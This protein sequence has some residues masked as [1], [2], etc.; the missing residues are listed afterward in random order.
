MPPAFIARTACREQLYTP[1]TFTLYTRSKSASVHYACPKTEATARSSVQAIPIQSVRDTATTRRHLFQCSN[2]NNARIVDEDVHAAV[3]RNDSVKR[4]FHGDG[5]CDVHSVGETRQSSKFLIDL[6]IEKTNVTS[7]I[8]VRSDLS[9]KTLTDAATEAVSAALMSKMWTKPPWRANSLEMDRPI[10]EAPPVTTAMV[11]GMTSETVETMTI[12]LGVSCTKSCTHRT[13]FLRQQNTAII[14]KLA[15]GIETE[16]AHRPIQTLLHGG[17]RK[18][19]LAWK[20]PIESREQCRTT[21][22]NLFTPTP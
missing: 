14:T 18:A 5:V 15:I 19:S 2:S 3:L 22:L 7:Q 12:Q 10:P 6:I 1:F 17:Q 11:S 16:H 21:K 4:S 13:L 20:N 9:S 8:C